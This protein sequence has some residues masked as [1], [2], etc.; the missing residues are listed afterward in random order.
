MPYVRQNMERQT[1]SKV[2][3][4]LSWSNIRLLDQQ[5]SSNIKAIRQNIPCNDYI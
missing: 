5:D 3:T 1:R 2:I 4:H